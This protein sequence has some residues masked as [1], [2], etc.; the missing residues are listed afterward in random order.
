MHQSAIERAITQIS[1]RATPGDILTKP[2]PVDVRSRINE[3]IFSNNNL[4]ETAS[5]TT[6]QPLHLNKGS[7]KLRNSH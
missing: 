4:A 6:K 1:T 2:V 3:I 5:E 7:N